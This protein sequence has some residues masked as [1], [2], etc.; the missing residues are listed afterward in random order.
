MKHFRKKNDSIMTDRRF[1]IIVLII[2][3]ITFEISVHHLIY[4]HYLNTREQLRKAEVKES[5]TIG[6]VRTY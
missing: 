3:N 4:P 6:S 5:Q 1:L 2:L